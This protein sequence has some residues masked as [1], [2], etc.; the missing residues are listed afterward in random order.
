L[1]IAVNVAPFVVFVGKTDAPAKTDEQIPIK[2]DTVA[3][4]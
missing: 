1:L 4:N 3:E 2:D